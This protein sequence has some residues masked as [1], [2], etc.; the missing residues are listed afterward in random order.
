MSISVS[1]HTIKS[2]L[3]SLNKMLETPNSNYINYYIKYLILLQFAYYCIAQ[4]ICKS[5]YTT[6]NV[7][8]TALNYYPASVMDSDMLS[9]A[10]LLLNAPLICPWGQILWDWRALSTLLLICS[11]VWMDVS[12]QKKAAEQVTTGAEEDRRN[13]GFLLSENLHWFRCFHVK[14]LREKT[15]F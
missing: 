1:V 12:L 9:T 5:K 3:V 4:H 8:K 13:S 15:C 6:G 7:F 11:T 2:I 10:T 14:N